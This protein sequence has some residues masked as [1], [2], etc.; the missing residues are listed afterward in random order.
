MRQSALQDSRRRHN[1]R[2]AANAAGGSGR[3]SV[4]RERAPLHQGSSCIIGGLK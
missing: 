2:D 1:R 3:P 4:G